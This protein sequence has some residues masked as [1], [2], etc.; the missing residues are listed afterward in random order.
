[1]DAADIAQQQSS[2]YESALYARSAKKSDVQMIDNGEV[3]C[4]RCKR[5]IPL[6]RLKAIPTSTHC[7][8]C[9]SMLS[10]GYTDFDFEEEELDE[11]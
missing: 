6:A 1:M 11:G 3:V 8:H 10:E 9:T 5:P 2:I 4:K 7:V